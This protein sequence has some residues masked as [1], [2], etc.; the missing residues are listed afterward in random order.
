MSSIGISFMRLNPPSVGHEM[1]INTMKKY[2]HLLERRIYLSSSHDTDKNPL[3]FEYRHRLAKMAFEDLDLTV[4][5]IPCKDWFDTLKFVGQ[6]GFA[7]LTVFVGGDRFPELDKRIPMYNGT[8]YQ[9]SKIKVVN[10]GNRDDSSTV[11]GMSATKLRAAA[12]LNDYDT[13]ERGLPLKLRSMSA[14]I[15]ERVREACLSTSVV[16]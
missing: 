1:L 9:F 2:T 8:L 10:V 14:D 7:E 15:Y 16:S 11:S 3:D 5:T 12:K 4:S 6:L 13:F